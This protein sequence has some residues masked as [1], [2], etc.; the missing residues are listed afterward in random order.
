MAHKTH[1]NTDLPQHAR[2]ATT[3]TRHNATNDKT[4]C[5]AAMTPTC[6]TNDKTHPNATL[7]HAQ[8]PLQCHHDEDYHNHV[9]KDDDS[10]ND[11][12]GTMAA[13]WQWQGR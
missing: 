7:S 4:C 11:G 5:D 1:H 6:P 13:G 10:N 3:P 12:V 2:L 8:D 9:S